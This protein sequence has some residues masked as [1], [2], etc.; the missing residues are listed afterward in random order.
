MIKFNLQRFCIDQISLNMY[1]RHM[2]YIHYHL[3]CFRDSHLA[4]AN[5]GPEFAPRNTH[6]NGFFVVVISI[7]NYANITVSLINNNKPL[8]LY[9]VCLCKITHINLHRGPK[10]PHF[11][12]MR[13]YMTKV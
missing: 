1:Y 5:L 11:C 7:R 2:F 6:F 13:R 10:C 3:V 8:Y 12:L 4:F 9:I